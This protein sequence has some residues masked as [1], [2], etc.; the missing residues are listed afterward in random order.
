MSALERQL[1]EQL[2]YAELPTPVTEWRFHPVRRWR[3]DL[4]WPDRMLAV[5]VQG[6]IYRG[7]GHTSVAGLKRD[8]EK[9]NAAT[10]LGWRVLLVHGDM[11]RD[12]TALA[13]IEDALRGDDTT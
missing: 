12:G 5:E 2:R 9:S 6:G 3:F 13:L 4:A 1:S 11:V 8:I 10:M 7:G